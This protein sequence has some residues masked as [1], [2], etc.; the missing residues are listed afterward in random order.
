MKILLAVILAVVFILLGTRVVSL[1]FQERQ[2]NQTLSDAE[3]KL[4]KAQADEANLSA[5]LQYLQN[6]SN[7]EKELRAQFNYKKPG[8]TMVVIV[9]Q[10]TSTAASTT[11]R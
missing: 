8:E 5:E 2:L 6:P 9:P 10:R 7:L 1:Y 4:Q 11:A 3:A